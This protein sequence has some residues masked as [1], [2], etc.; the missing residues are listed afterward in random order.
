MDKEQA[1]LEILQKC[2]FKPR[3]GSQ[4]LSIPCPLAPYTP[5]HKNNWDSHPSM[6][7]KVTEGSVL[8]NCFTCHFKSGQLSY[9]FHRLNSHDR[10]WGEALNAVVELESKYLSQGLDNLK[11]MGLYVDKNKKSSEPLD[12]ALF[13]PFSR[14]FAPYLQRRGVT[15]DTG[16]RWGVGVDVKQKRAVIPVRDFSGALWGAVGRSYINQNPKY[17]NYWEMKKGTQLLGA[18]LIKQSKTTI[19]VEGSLDALLTDQALRSLGFEDQYNVVSILGA[20][21]S[22]KQ[23]NLLVRCSNDVIVALDADEAGQKGL[24]R[25]KELLSTRLLSKRADISTVG[26]KDFGECSSQEIL[27]VISNSALL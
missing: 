9:L 20:S 15:I 16:K 18:H 7:I 17:M 8:V 11:S 4:N 3:R 10:K 14:Q 23:A 27:E 21:L 6:G 5:L 22:E 12:E 26:K 24:L 19:I 13:S 1:I 25:A 2:N